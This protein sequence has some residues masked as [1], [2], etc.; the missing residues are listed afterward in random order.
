MRNRHLASG[1]AEYAAVQRGCSVELLI[2]QCRPRMQIGDHEAFRCEAPTQVD[3]EVCAQEVCG[4]RILPVKH[5]NKNGVERTPVKQRACC[6]VI[7][8]IVCLHV[9][10]AAV[11]SKPL[12]R[13]S[14]N[15]SVQFNGNQLVVLR[16]EQ[17]RE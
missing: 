1:A 6:H 11:E 4:D 14:D 15:C 3:Q 17:R 2:K 8:R 5:V 9:N 7:K 16:L 13:G 10:T 12:L